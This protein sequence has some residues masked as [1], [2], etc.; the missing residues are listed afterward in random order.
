MEIQLSRIV[1]GF[2][3]KLSGY[4]LL[5][6]TEVGTFD[7][8][9]IRQPGGEVIFVAVV[10]TAKDDGQFFLLLYDLLQHFQTTFLL[11]LDVEDHKVDVACFKELGG[12]TAVRSSNDLVTSSFNSSE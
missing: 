1:S 2:S 5:Q 4:L 3:C 7:D 6:F 8:V 9:G 12:L 11:D 10:G